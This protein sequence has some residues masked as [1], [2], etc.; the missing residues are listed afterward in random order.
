VLPPTRPTR[1]ST[2]TTDSRYCELLLSWPML[3][4]YDGS[5]M[6]EFVYPMAVVAFD[7]SMTMNSGSDSNCNAPATV[8]RR[9]D[10][11]PSA[12]SPSLSV[13]ADGEGDCSCCL[14]DRRLFRLFRRRRRCCCCCFFLGCESS[15]RLTNVLPWNGV[16]TYR[17][18][19]SDDDPFAP[20]NAGACRLQ[21]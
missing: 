5:R 17:S 16:L 21:C 1:S 3:M 10:V 11:C 20:R 7:T 18:D 19:D 6:A 4:A 12:P 15:Y 14:P 9:D 13:F 2:A 8:L